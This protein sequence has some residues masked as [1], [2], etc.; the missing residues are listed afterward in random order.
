MEKEVLNYK[1]EKLL[2]TIPKGKKGVCL[3][4]GGKDSD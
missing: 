1:D 3:Y 2:G 4:S